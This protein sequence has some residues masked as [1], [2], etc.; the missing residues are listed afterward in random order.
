MQ[1]C[2]GH[3]RRLQRR[4]GGS[5]QKDCSLRM[6]DGARRMRKGTRWKLADS[7]WG[8]DEEYGIETGVLRLGRAADGGVVAAGGAGADG[9]AAAA[10]AAGVVAGGAVGV[11]GVVGVGVVG[12]VV[13]KEGGWT[14]TEH[15]CGGEKDG[16]A[17]GDC[18]GDGVE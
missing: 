17:G 9:V 16:G 2:G 10:A 1:M 3:G 8:G 18:G 4:G 15:V 5:D 11:V 13:E 7:A 14:E 6:T 12:V